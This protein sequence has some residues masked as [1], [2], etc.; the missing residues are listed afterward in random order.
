[1]K[2][3]SVVS[4]TRMDKHG[5][6]IMK[7]ALEEIA[8]SFN[9]GPI[10]I[11][12]EHIPFVPPIG[13][14]IAGRVVLSGDG[15]HELE[16]IQDF[17]ENSRLLVAPDEEVLI[18]G[19][20]EGNK[21]PFKKQEIDMRSDKLIKISY[22]RINFTTKN[23][24]EFEMQIEEIAYTQELIR[25]SE[26]PDPVVI[27]SFALTFTAWATM[28]VYKTADKL[29]DK[30]SEK[31]ADEIAGDGIKI[32]KVIRQTIIGFI[33][34]ANP[35]YK[36]PTIIF[37]SQY[38]IEDRD[39]QLEFVV[40]TK[41]IDA[42]DEALLSVSNCEPQIIQY[43]KSLMAQK[44][45]FMYNVSTKKWKFNYMFNDI[46]EVI[47]AEVAWNNAQRMFMK[48]QGKTIDVK[49][50]AACPCGSGNNYEICCGA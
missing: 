2:C 41:N 36:L 29:A 15:E 17:F 30:L 39:I 42:I 13:K 48:Y 6:I 44:I 25:K 22:D 37:E 49:G 40:R 12:V 24:R 8:Q 31:L 18:V 23:I 46:G 9:E 14:V 32:Y 33:H 3:R 16:V 4:S 43:S 38:L 27:F 47:G 7:E 20:S 50:N 11:L 28:F 45:Q 35:P 26:L 34:K 5:M 19:G 1:V 10:P 21:L